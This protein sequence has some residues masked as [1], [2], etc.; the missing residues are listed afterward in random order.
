MELNELN[1]EVK[2]LQNKMGELLSDIKGVEERIER[3][4]SKPDNYVKL[5]V[6]EISEE[7]LLNSWLIKVGRVVLPGVIFLGILIWMGGT[8]YG[9]IQIDSI[10]SLADSATEKITASVDR[11]RKMTAS[12]DRIRKEMTASAE[13]VRDAEKNVNETIKRTINDI[14]EDTTKDIDD[15]VERVETAATEAVNKNI[16]KL[17]KKV[18]VVSEKA[19]SEEIP[20]LVNSLSEQ[21]K[22]DMV[23]M[24][25]QDSHFKNQVVDENNKRMNSLLVELKARTPIG[26]VIPFYLNPNEIEKMAPNWLPADGSTVRNKESKLFGKKLPD[27]KDRFVLGA[28]PEANIYPESEIN[29]GGTTKVI[30]SGFTGEVKY[31]TKHQEQEGVDTPPLNNGFFLID[32]K[33]KECYWSNHKHSAEVSGDISLPPY[34]RLIYMVRVK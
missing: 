28:S 27:L 29:V 3:V 12:V 30:L 6:K 11:I 32:T 20:N 10:G 34:R 17:V 26:A 1:K 33:D 8:I 21:V 13:R 22:S 24:I 2:G 31:T 19:V 16:P 15:A 14:K 7:V 25:L 9:K 23:G 4:K 18:N 5:Y